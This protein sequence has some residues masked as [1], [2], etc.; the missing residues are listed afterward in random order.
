MRLTR[1]HWSPS[2]PGTDTPVTKYLR[3]TKL[4]QNES[5]TE[6]NNLLKCKNIQNVVR[7]YESWS[8][9]SEKR[10]QRSKLEYATTAQD[11]ETVLCVG[12]IIITLASSSDVFRPHYV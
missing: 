5:K 11:F 12:Y 3:S 7:S 6:N 4:P 10:L 1:G 2:R 8:K 9:E